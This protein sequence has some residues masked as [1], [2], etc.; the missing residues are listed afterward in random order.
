M[1]GDIPGLTAYRWRTIIRILG[2][3]MDKRKHCP[4]C[5]AIA[6]ESRSAF[7]RLICNSVLVDDELTQFLAGLFASEEN[8]GHLTELWERN[9]FADVR[10]RWLQHKRTA[11]PSGVFQYAEPI[12]STLAAVLTRRFQ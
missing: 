2:I 5:D 6:T 12:R 7:I 10:Q 8:L 9:E 3:E 1:L 11:G 4:E